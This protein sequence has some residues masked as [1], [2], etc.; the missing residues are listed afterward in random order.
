MSASSVQSELDTLHPQLWR[1]SQ[2]AR[3]S[4]RCIDTGHPALA[5]HLPDGGW[6]AGNLVELLCQNGIGEVRLIA[7]AL[8]RVVNRSVV[9]LQPP[10]APQSLALAAFG[11]PPAYG[12]VNLRTSG[13]D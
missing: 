4:A 3:S 9:F 13:L 11:L 10:H 8:E 12:E 6:P 5:R 1:A 2:L 7:E